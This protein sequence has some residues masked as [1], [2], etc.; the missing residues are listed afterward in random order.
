MLIPH[1][2]SLNQHTT[3]PVCWQRETEYLLTHITKFLDACR[4]F[5]A[6]HE[7]H[8]AQFFHHVSVPCAYCL[9]RI[10]L[11]NKLVLKCHHIPMDLLRVC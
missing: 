8:L 5:L 1:D 2:A 4:I 7:P 11:M 9:L 3:I 6:L 10:L